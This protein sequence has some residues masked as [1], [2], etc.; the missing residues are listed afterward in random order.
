MLEFVLLLSND[1]AKLRYQ[2]TS[3]ADGGRLVG[4]PRQ[5][6]YVCIATSVQHAMQSGQ[7]SVAPAARWTPVWQL[8]RHRAPAR[9]TQIELVSARA[10]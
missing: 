10:C 6:T 3:T 4:H 9:V 2:R 5:L 1:P 8:V 7:R